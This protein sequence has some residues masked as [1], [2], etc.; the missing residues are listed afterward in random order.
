[1]SNSAFTPFVQTNFP[2]ASA[3][4]SGMVTTSAQTFAGKKTLDGGAL[5]K[6]ATDGVAIAAGYVGEKVISLGSNGVNKTGLNGAPVIFDTANA[7]SL[8]LGAGTWL[9]IG[10]VGLTTTNVS[11][12]V[13]LTIYNNTDSAIIGYGGTASTTVNYES[14]LTAMA[15]FTHSSI[16]SKT[17]YLRGD[18]NGG[19]ILKI[20]TAGA[21]CVSGYLIAVRI[22]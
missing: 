12:N 2:V 5:I 13:F 18:R 10:N 22:A 14:N 4:V 8:S 20:G 6:G 7:P 16:T 15:I 21:A 1:M 3:T 19:S 9:I 17:I 11:D